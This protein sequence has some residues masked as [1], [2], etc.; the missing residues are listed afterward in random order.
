MMKFGQAEGPE[1]RTVTV[2]SIGKVDSKNQ[3]YQKDGRNRNVIHHMEQGGGS[4]SYVVQR[5]SVFCR[6]KSLELQEDGSMSKKKMVNPKPNKY[7]ETT[8]V[9]L[10]FF[11]HSLAPELYT[12]RRALNN[13]L[14]MAPRVSDDTSN[15]TPVGY[16][17]A[18]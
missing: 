11:K 4:A 10:L 1:R 3:P 14:P 15:R 16:S 12:Q 6:L 17:L 13:C 18:S 8:T 7:P 5:S 2:Y 9:I